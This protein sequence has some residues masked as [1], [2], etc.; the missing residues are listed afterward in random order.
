[1]TI[2]NSVTIDDA[3][4]AYR[5]SG[6]GPAIVLVNG[7][8]AVDL[9]WGGVIERLS[10]C[11]TVISLDYSGAGDTIDDGSPLTLP[12]LARQV[13]AAAV[14]AGVDT[15]DLV[16]HSLGAAVAVTLAAQ[17]PDRVRSL[18]LVAGF[19]WGGA[20]RMKLLFELWRDL[21]QTNREAYVKLLALTALS[22]KFF[23]S[24]M[25]ADLD[26]LM[27][28]IIVQ[29]DWDGLARQIDLD[30]MVDI[31]SEVESIRCRTL[32]VECAHD[33]ITTDSKIIAEK[34]PNSVYKKIDAGH[35]AYFEAGDTFVEILQ[36]FIRIS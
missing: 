25:A 21:I 22:D 4:V 3:Q 5:V 35:Q 30:L 11:R 34:I 16:G 27:T 28:T 13:E 19:L 24:R 1:M 33:C 7:T 36:E 17:R 2:A 9:H 29:T 10:R 26:A 32:V 23:Q 8:G 31:R 18:T 15:F 20:P 6:Q 14:A 12:K